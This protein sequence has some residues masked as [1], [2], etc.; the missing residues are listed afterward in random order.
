MLP[1]RKMML[2]SCK[3]AAR[4]SALERNPD[5][6]SIKAGGSSSAPGELPLE[7][8]GDDSDDDSSESPLPDK[9]E[10]DSGEERLYCP[11]VE[12]D[13][14]GE[15]CENWTPKFGFITVEGLGR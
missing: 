12:L 3:M 15:V 1:P 9:P 4:R 8:D 13:W 5:P 11:A 14:D 7:P 10:L 2:P 6:D